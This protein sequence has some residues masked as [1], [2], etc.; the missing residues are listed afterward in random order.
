MWPPYFSP[1]LML[2]PNRVTEPKSG[3]SLEIRTTE[4]GMQFYCGGFLGGVTGRE[5]K[6]WFLVASTVFSVTSHTALSHPL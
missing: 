2:R 3:R 4:P 6:V 5:G 1:N